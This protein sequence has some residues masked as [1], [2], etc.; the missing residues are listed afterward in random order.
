M[1]VV[2]AIDQVDLRMGRELEV[3]YFGE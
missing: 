3:G 2:E 1:E